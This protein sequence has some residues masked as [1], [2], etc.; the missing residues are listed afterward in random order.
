MPMQNKQKLHNHTKHQT[1]AKGYSIILMVSRNCNL[2]TK[3]SQCPG[4]KETKYLTPMAPIK[5]K[6]PQNCTD[7]ATIR[8]E[9]AE[10]G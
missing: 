4:R 9:G 1:K 6:N 7:S 10:L 8:I 2:L 3:M 5:K